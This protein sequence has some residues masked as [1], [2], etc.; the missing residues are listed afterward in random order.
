M[1]TQ[2]FSESVLIACTSN[3]AC[4]DLP[5][6]L[7]V[8][9]LQVVNHWYFYGVEKLDS[10]LRLWCKHSL[11]KHNS[12]FITACGVVLIAVDG[13]A[14]S[15]LGLFSIPPE[16]RFSCTFCECVDLTNSIIQQNIV[17]D[18]LY[19]P[20][21]YSSPYFRGKCGR[22][23]DVFD[24]L[25]H[26]QYPIQWNLSIMESYG[27]QYLSTIRFQELPYSEVSLCAG[28]SSIEKDFFAIQ[29]ENK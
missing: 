13:L 17:R 16:D 20:G 8:L 26:N 11:G 1:F 12:V 3:C 7:Y 24:C 5:I 2:L 19:T 10:F 25:T 15:P 14:S 28:E 27:T 18:V 4:I 23:T 9:Y 6:S 22:L 29:V 21:V